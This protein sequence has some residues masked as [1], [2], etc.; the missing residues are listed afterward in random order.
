[1]RRYEFVHE[2]A[3]LFIRFFEHVH[4]LLLCAVD[5][6]LPDLLEVVLELPIHLLLVL[7]AQ[8]FVPFLYF[9]NFSLAFFDY[10]VDLGLYSFQCGF[11]DLFQ[12]SGLPLLPALL[13]CLCPYFPLFFVILLEGV[14]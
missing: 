7:V 11:G 3:I 1:M 2:L 14:L 5:D 4:L 9:C 13:F 8:L 10:S 12:F 6:A